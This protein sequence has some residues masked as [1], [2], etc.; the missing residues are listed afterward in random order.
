MNTFI[1]KILNYNDFKGY[2]KIDLGKFI[3]LLTLLYSVFYF[4]A[5]PSNTKSAGLL[6]ELFLLIS[7]SIIGYFL[8]HYFK[9]EQLKI[10]IDFKKL[11]FGFSLL[12]IFIFFKL[13]NF[14]LVGDEINY[15]FKSYCLS[16]TVF[17]RLMAKIPILENYRYKLF[18]SIFNICFFTVIYF[19]FQKNFYRNLTFYL[20][21]ILL[22]RLTFFYTYLG[23]VLAPYIGFN[24]VHP[25][26]SSLAGSIFTIFLGIDE[27]GF[28]ISSILFCFVFFSVISSY[29]KFN[30]VQIFLVFTF[31][32]LFD[33]FSQNI[34]VIEQA[35][36]L[37]YFII[38][39]LINYTKTPLKQISLLVGISIL[40]R[41]TGIILFFI[42]VLLAFRSGIYNF[43]EKLKSLTPLIIGVP[44]FFKAFVEGTPSTNSSNKFNLFIE[45]F[46]GTILRPEIA[47]FLVLFVLYFIVKKNQHLVLLFSIIFILYVILLARTPF[48]FSNK[49]YFEIFSGFMVF[50]VLSIISKIDKKHEK[51]FYLTS[52]ITCLLFNSFYKNNYSINKNYLREVAISENY[53]FS[54]K[55]IFPTESSSFQNLILYSKYGEYKKKFHFQ[56]DYL[57]CFGLGLNRST[58][59]VGQRTKLDTTCISLPE[60]APKKIFFLNHNIRLEPLKSYSFIKTNYKIKHNVNYTE[61]IKKQ[62]QN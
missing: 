53:D 56:L 41:F 55:L 17:E 35:N 60:N 43:K 5:I 7:P 46:Y 62:S 27:V 58:L 26:L 19:I 61:C 54:D 3:F 23:E 13:N 59:K 15:S 10:A 52:V 18:L 21:I 38:T 25:P 6:Y 57:E 33:F 39:L 24:N 34:Q 30:Y 16:L 20:L 12:L 47:L 40:F 44:L 22:F 9:S 32:F 28:R 2:L 37:S 49:Y 1:R 45:E 11:F 48:N 31:Y 36:Y 42:P 51:L 14:C 29:L 50:S 8:I 4:G